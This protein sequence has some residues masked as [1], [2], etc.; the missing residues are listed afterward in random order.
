MRPARTFPVSTEVQQSTQLPPKPPANAAVGTMWVD[1]QAFVL[2]IKA[3]DGTWAEAPL[4]RAEA[5]TE[6]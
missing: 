4:F 6:G 3:P 1:W 5:S 2:K